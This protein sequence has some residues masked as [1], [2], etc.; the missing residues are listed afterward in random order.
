MDLVD[1]AVGID[2]NGRVLFLFYLLGSICLW[3]LCILALSSSDSNV[4]IA[5]RHYLESVS[6]IEQS[7]TML[8]VCLLLLL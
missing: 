6:D 3:M 8:F 5:Q 2:P 1:F 7:L 4:S